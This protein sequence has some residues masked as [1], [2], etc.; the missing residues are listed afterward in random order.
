MN[1]I[2]LSLVLASS[3]AGTAFGNEPAAP[4][5]EKSVSELASGCAT[6]HGPNGAAPVVPGAPILAGQEESYLIA[7]MR[8]YRLAARIDAGKV[9]PVAGMLIRKNAL[10]TPQAAS[11]SDTQIKG[12]ARFF[13]V[14]VSTLYTKH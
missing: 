2:I 13:N 14:Q 9:K 4:A 10:M 11:L 6:C 3:L 1:K 12:L 8:S 7:A 5:T